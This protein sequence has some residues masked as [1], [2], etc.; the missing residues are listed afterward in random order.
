MPLLTFEDL[1]L[2]RHDRWLFRHLHG[3]IEVGQRTALV[4]PN[5]TGKTSLLRLLAGQEAPDEGRVRPSANLRLA[6]MWQE[7]APPP[8]M[9]LAPYAES[10]LG[11]WT[12]SRRALEAAEQGL[13]LNPTPS[14]LRELGRLDDRF[15]AL[16][17]WQV[18]AELDRQL[19]LL[20][21]DKSDW[22]RPVAELSGGQRM[23]IR[24]AALAAQ[25]AS[26]WILDE[27]TNHLDRDGRAWLRRRLEEVP[28]F[29]IVA[30]DPDFLD[31]LTDQV[32]HLEPTGIAVYN[33]GFGAYLAARQEQ[34]SQRAAESA[35]LGEERAKLEAFIRK[36]GSGTRARQAKDRE[37]KLA[38]LK[39]PPPA[40]RPPAARPRFASDD[41]SG[42]L[43]LAED[44]AVGIGER[45]LA[46]GLTITLEA[47]SRLVVSGPNGAG[48]TTLLRTLA[49]ELRP[50]AGRIRLG[51]GVRRAWVAQSPTWPDPALDLVSH[52]MRVVGVPTV[53]AAI[54]LL[55]R[56]GL[57]A[58]RETAVGRLSGGE[59]TRL[60]IAGLEATGAS[61]LLLDEPTNN[62]DQAAQEGLASALAEYPG[63]V[64]VATH[65]RR[66]GQ[67]LKADTLQIGRYQGETA[68][69]AKPPARSARRAPAAPAAAGP[70][71]SEE[72]AALERRLDQLAAQMAAPGLTPPDRQRLAAEAQRVGD[73]L[74]RAWTAFAA[75][76][77]TGGGPPR[78]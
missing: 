58:H 66:F 19:G 3:V 14:Q 29:L 42:I 52:L 16:G 17:G 46:E 51:N 15:Q 9:A 70:D 28:T 6:A 38:R 33:L 1:G 44:L 73:D 78:G 2:S 74:E 31:G 57:A 20:E 54:G 69:R 45:C 27:P 37:R 41:R 72:I 8:A 59:Q 7:D 47:G 63:A 21:L 35:R 49:G 75:V 40:L 23:R 10:L 64:V 36:F 4:A 25:G 77:G 39:E 34:E 76:Q 65:D 62:L 43:L 24:I 26:L 60:A 18:R 71:W 30:H 68:E 32:W 48:K 50:L 12:L 11:A 53:Q 61:V 55:A 56:Y 13:G 5:G 67:L 22:T